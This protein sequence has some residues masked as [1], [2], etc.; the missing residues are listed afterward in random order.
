MVLLAL[1]NNQKA[2]AADKS[3]VVGARLGV[4]LPQI[5]SELE[6]NMVGTVEGGYI[7]PWIDGRVQVFGA[8]AYAQPEH[9]ET[10][11]D[12]RFA[13]IG[14][15]YQFTTIQRE[16]T[17]DLGVLGRLFSIESTFNA[18]LALGP[19]LYLLETETYGEAG[20]EQFGTNKEQSTKVGVYA[21]LGGEMWLG[22][23]MLL[24]QL[25]LAASD[26]GHDITGDVS[27]SAMMFSI[28]YRFVF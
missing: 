24:A 7:L 21:A 9:S 14:G 11:E 16:L 22:P 27:T 1:A 8:F 25:S 17:I 2:Q 15:T 6:T 10:V 12:A 3:I 19:R 28:G 5:S 26:L 18:Y 4:F 13:A 23:G 20:G